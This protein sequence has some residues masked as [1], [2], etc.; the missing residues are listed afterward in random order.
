[1]PGVEI[2]RRWI[3]ETELPDLLAWSD[4]LV[5]PYREASQSGVAAAA[6][7]QG[8]YV[9]ATNVGGLA[10]QL[11]GKAGVTLCP[12]SADAIATG[13][14]TLFTQPP[15]PPVN[16]TDDWREMATKLMAGLAP[17]RTRELAKK[18]LA[19]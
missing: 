3:A 12:A 11:A 4:A 5:L 6:L 19:V 1:M 17:D 9:L 7:A 13:L 18:A 10:E 15:P 8:R 2:D 14:A 16:A